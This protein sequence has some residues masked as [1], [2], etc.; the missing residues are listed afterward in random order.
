MVDYLYERLQRRG[1]LRR[2]VERMVNQ[3]RNI[4][5]AALLALG[6][7][8][9]MITGV[10]RPFGQTMRQVRRVL[11]RSRARRRSAST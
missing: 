8:D 5:A 1:Y 9:A 6:E 7:G 11:D 4:F 2:E 10:T 3:D